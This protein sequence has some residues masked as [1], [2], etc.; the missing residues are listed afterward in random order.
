LTI[1]EINVRFEDAPTS[2]RVD[3]IML[4]P[5]PANPDETYNWTPGGVFKT[6]PP[7]VLLSDRSR[8][9]IQRVVEFEGYEVPADGEARILLLMS[10]KDAGRDTVTAHVVTY[11]HRGVTYR[12]VLPEGLIT[13]VAEA[14][15]L[16]PNR[17]ERPC[18]DQVAV[19]P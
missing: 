2:V 1:K 13:S 11:R 18:F 10:A 15:H 5:L 16:R 12:Q 4:A 8:C 19:L 7:A 17:I 14:T 6:F 9:N 3:D